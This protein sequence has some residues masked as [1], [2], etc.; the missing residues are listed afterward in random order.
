MTT[1]QSQALWELCR[2]GLPL[3]A[4]E[5]AR[6]WTHGQHFELADG[7]R[8]TRYLVA[9]IRQCNWEVERSERTLRLQGY[10]P[11]QALHQPPV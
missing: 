11:W 4:D 7:I 5:A 6:M 9:L 2:Q 3:E 10:L 1:N 8:L